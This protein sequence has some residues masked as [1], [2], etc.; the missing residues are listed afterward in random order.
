MVSARHGTLAN[1]LI[2]L[3]VC[4]ASVGMLALAGSFDLATA[5]AHGGGNGHGHGPGYPPKVHPTW[6]GAAG[7]GQGAPAPESLMDTTGE[8]TNDAIDA[9]PFTEYFERGFSG[10]IPHWYS[11]GELIK[12]GE[13]VPVATS[14]ELTFKHF[15]SEEFEVNCKLNDKETIENLVG[16]GAGLDTL[17]WLGFSSCVYGL[18]GDLPGH[19]I[20]SCTVTAKALPWH[21]R[22]LSGSPV[23]DEI[24]GM[25]VY[26]DCG[27]YSETYTGSLYPQVGA[28]VLTF[29]SA[30]GELKNQTTPNSPVVGYDLIEGPK[31]DETITVET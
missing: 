16:G 20:G 26:V 8:G 30:T 7:V 1:R 2:F 27:V 4:L 31:G 28:S 15:V 29:T 11:N 18:R 23:A 14:G 12:E 19:P 3:A 9:S 24:T 13:E 5:S 10:P 22:L 6:P 25:E 17:R 21:T